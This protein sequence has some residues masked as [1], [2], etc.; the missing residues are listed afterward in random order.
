MSVHI[1]DP[2]ANALA[3]STYVSQPPNSFTLIFMMENG[4]LH[5]YPLPSNVG[6]LIVLAFD[7]MMEIDSP[8]HD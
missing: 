1:Q 4:I 6:K 5:H 8:Q 3:C 7:L 2:T